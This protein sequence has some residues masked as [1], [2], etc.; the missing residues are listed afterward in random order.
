MRKYTKYTIYLGIFL[1]S[2]GGADLIGSMNEPIKIS[3]PIKMFLVM[4]KIFQCN[5][6]MY[7]IISMYRVSCKYGTQS[8]DKILEK[9][10]CIFNIVN[11]S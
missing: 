2:G 4:Q 6:Q 8:N 1:L 5:I 11:G 3:E 9:Y 7:S 10:I